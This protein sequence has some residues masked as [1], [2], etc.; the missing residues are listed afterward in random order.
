MGSSDP[1]GEEGGV[2]RP[3]RRGDGVVRTH[4][5]GRGVVRPHRRGGGVVRTHRR[6]GGIVRTHRRCRGVI[7]PLLRGRWSHQLGPSLS[8]KA[9]ELISALTSEVFALREGLPLA[10]GSPT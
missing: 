3:H 10:R 5:R 1:T 4:R 2:I 6:G 7:R 9:P 8:E